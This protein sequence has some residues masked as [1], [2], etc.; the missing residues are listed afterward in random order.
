MRIKEW[1]SW[2]F[3]ELKTLVPDKI[4]YAR[5]VEFIKNKENLD[6]NVVEDLG[7]IVGSEEVA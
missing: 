1:F 2:H 7:E 3:P 5:A 6:D 4:V